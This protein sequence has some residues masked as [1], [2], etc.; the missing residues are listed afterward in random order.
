MILINEIIEKA[1]I[2]AERAHSEVGQVRKYSGLPYIIHPISVSN[3]VN[4]LA[5]DIEGKDDA[6]CAAL[7][8]DTVEDTK[9]VLE[10]IYEE[11]GGIVGDMVFYLTDISQKEDGNRAFRKQKDLDHNC[12][13]DFWAQTVKCC[14][15]MDNT[16]DITAFDCNFA[17]T[18]LKE[19]EKALAALT[20]AA[21]PVREHAKNVLAAA[22]TNLMRATL[23]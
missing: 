20:K 11:F 7:L 2:F 14:D 10:D 5:P 13:G 18:Y 4:V 21:D 19:K 23:K 8:H 6:I 22:Q 16:S 1:R 12:K 17:Q 9:V 3:Y 15:L